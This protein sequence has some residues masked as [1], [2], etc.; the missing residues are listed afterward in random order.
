MKVMDYN[1]EISPNW[2]E[3]FEGK[4]D[5]REDLYRDEVF[6]TVNYL[7]LRKIK[8][9]MEENQRSMEKDHSMDEQMVLLQIHQ[10]L[11]QLEI[12]LT[13]KLGTVIFK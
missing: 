12:D 13:K 11:K 7:K 2:K 4:I 6:S 1:T 8:R 3:I 5:T 9:M 10:H